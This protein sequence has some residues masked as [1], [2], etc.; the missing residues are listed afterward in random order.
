MTLNKRDIQ[1]ER[2]NVVYNNR[3]QHGRFIK[4]KNYK[5]C[6]KLLQCTHWDNNNNY[7]CYYCSEYKWGELEFK[8]YEDECVICKTIANTQVKFP[9]C[10]H[11]FCV[12]CSNKILIWD[13]SQYHL[14]PVKFGCP[15]CP[16]GCDNP[17]RGKQCECEEYQRI[18]DK[19]K[20]N[21]IDNYNQWRTLENESIE[22]SEITEGSA[23]G[24]LSCPLC[25]QAQYVE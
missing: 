1:Y 25:R 17:E 18:I 5:L 13:S 7:I 22:L 21:N 16:K 6:N 15:P 2:L 12:V 20:R 23:F 24:S 8:I 11:W 3:F 14:S 4:C 19:W 10:T 9:Y